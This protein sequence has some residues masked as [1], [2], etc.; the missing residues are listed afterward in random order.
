MSGRAKGDEGPLITTRNGEFAHILEQNPLSQSTLLSYL[1]GIWQ[2]ECT[3]DPDRHIRGRGWGGQ[4]STPRDNGGPGL[5]NSFFQPFGPQF[6]L[7][8]KEGCPP[9]PSPGSATDVGKLKG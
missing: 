4:S 5:Q 6:G 3:S 8:I 1:E 7:K 2:L 9:G